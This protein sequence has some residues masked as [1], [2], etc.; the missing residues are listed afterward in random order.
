MPQE[1]T[2]LLR[3]YPSHVEHVPPHFIHLHRPFPPSTSMMELKTIIVMQR[4][5]QDTQ[6]N[7]DNTH[8]VHHA[9]L[10][11]WSA[12][13]GIE[14]WAIALWRWRMGACT[15][16]KIWYNTSSHDNTYNIAQISGHSMCLHDISR[17]EKLA[18]PY[19]RSSMSFA[20]APSK[21]AF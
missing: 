9:Q 2:A 10:V 19:N 16:M 20:P 18:P 21:I 7:K 12:N 11:T 1:S 14:V 6:K 3:A 8:T 17:G 13:T 15:R 5:H 4:H